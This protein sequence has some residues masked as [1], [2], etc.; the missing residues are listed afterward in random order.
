MPR[1][2]G[3]ILLLAGL[4]TSRWMLTPAQQ[5][6]PPPAAVPAALPAAPRKHAPIPRPAAAPEASRGGAMP[7]E[8]AWNAG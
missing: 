2:L 1:L 4:A 7:S 5:P 8:Q 6:S 3:L